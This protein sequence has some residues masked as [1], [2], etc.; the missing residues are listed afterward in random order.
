MLVPGG[1]R[2]A[3]GFKNGYHD[4]CGRSVLLR[5]AR[6]AKVFG[7]DQGLVGQF[8]DHLAA[9]VLA[10]LDRSWP[11]LIVWTVGERIRGKLQDA[12]LPVVQF[13]SVPNSVTGITS[14]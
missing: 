2:S 11:Q 9:F 5:C 6:G 7:S 4:N 10:E 1:G 14:L 8:N 13:Y 12:G 3:I